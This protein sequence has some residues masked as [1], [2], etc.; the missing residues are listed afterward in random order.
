M[1]SFEIYYMSFLSS[2][3][4]IFVIAKL[5]QTNICSE[6]EG[7]QV[8]LEV[9]KHAAVEAQNFWHHHFNKELI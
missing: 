7:Q 1:K 6:L 5:I 3:L 9:L 2:L 8:H 4:D